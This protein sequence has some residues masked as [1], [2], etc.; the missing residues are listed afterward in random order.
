MHNL[1]AIPILSFC[2]STAYLRSVASF[3]FL[4]RGVPGKLPL[5]SAGE[6][7]IEALIHHQELDQQ[8]LVQ[9]D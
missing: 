8:L 4:M 6:R 3:R 2:S 5:T 1:Q 7:V 9:A